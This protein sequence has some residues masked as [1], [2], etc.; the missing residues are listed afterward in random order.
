MSKVASLQTRNTAQTDNVVLMILKDR[1][2]IAF[3]VREE[4]FVNAPI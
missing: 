2:M 1:I 4:K 3:L